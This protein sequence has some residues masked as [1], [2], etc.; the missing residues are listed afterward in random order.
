MN[1]IYRVHGAGG[2][3]LYGNAEPGPGFPNCPPEGCGHWSDGAGVVHLDG[4]V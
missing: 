4:P 2:F 3:F 1:V